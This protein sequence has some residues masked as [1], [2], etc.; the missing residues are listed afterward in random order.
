MNRETREEQA[1]KLARRIGVKLDRLFLIE[2]RPQDY[3]LTRR[4]L[5][6]YDGNKNMWLRD[7]EALPDL[8]LG[9]LKIKGGDETEKDLPN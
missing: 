1:E 4:G 6:Y 9:N 2:D 8:L 5:L 7:Y 3:C